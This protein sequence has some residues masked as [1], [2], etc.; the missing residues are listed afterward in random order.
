[1][2]ENVV[3][4]AGDGI[5]L[6]FSQTL[7]SGFEVSLDQTNAHGKQCPGRDLVPLGPLP[8][9]VRKLSLVKHMS[10]GYFTLVRCES[11][12]VSSGQRTGKGPQSETARR[13]NS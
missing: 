11:G 4:H 9:P 7:G 8:S 10:G 1:M 13:G 6:H 5:N 2:L 3:F 12:V